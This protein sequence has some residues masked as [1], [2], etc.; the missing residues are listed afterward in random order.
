M[1]RGLGR[2]QGDPSDVPVIGGF[3]RWMPA[4]DFGTSYAP[5]SGAVKCTAARVEEPPGLRAF[6]APSRRHSE[7]PIEG[8]RRP[9]NCY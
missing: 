7:R 6:R 3:G 5:D 9:R 4:P 1:S 2:H 8:A